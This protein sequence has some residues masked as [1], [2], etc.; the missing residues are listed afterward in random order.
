M[1]HAMTDGSPLDFVTNWCVAHCNGD[2]EH[3]VGI[4][5]ETL[6][7]PGWA[8]DVRIAETELEGVATE[9][10]REE[11]SAEDWLHWRSTGEMFEARCGPG[12]VSQAL[13]ALTRSRTPR[14]PNVR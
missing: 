13:A 7:N 6:D 14:G 4:K 9:W 10:R 8:V 1:L 3:D 12:N 11:A 5:I 2:W